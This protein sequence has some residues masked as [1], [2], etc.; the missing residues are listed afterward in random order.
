MPNL[1]DGLTDVD[2]LHIALGCRFGLDILTVSQHYPSALE[3]GPL[4]D[5]PEFS[6]FLSA[7]STLSFC[8]LCLPSG[9]HCVVSVALIV[10]CVHL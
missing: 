5:D 2:V 9:L 8:P 3:L 7:V 6:L 1:L 4:P 10:M